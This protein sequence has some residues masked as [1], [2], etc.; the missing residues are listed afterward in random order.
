MDQFG[1]Y[2]FNIDPS[3]FKIYSMNKYQ[4]HSKFAKS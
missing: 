2:L 1:A 4:K 3:F